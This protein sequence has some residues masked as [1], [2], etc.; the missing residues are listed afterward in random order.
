MLDNLVKGMKIILNEIQNK[1]L[2]DNE[3]NIEIQYATYNSEVQKI[4]NYINKYNHKKVIVLNEEYAF[5]EI[6]T[7]EIIMFYSDKRYNYCK[8]KNKNYRVKQKLYEIENTDEDFI[9]IS[10]NCIVNIKHVEKF[11]IGETGKIIVILDDESRQRVS[12]RRTSDIMK[13]LE[14]RR[15]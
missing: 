11:D 7:N 13:F 3:L 8:T 1:K 6:E 14:E 4:I 2:K 5:V 9:R 15:I 10:K 12:R